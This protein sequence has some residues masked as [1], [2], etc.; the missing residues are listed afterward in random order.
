M[1]RIFYFLIFSG[2]FLVI[3]SVLLKTWL[4]KPLPVLATVG[5]FELTD[6]QSQKFSEKNL[7]NKVW[8]VD[9]IFTRC[10]GPCP[11]MTQKMQT[12]HNQFL[13]NDGVQLVTVTVDPEY[14]TPEILKKYAQKYQ[15]TPQKWHFLTGEK[16]KIESLMFDGFKLGFADDIVFHSDRL[17]LVDR[18][19]KIRGYYSGSEKKDFKRLQ[20]DLKRLL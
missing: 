8:V 19:L 9:F 13:K 16:K 12:L 6:S 3:F 11:L 20:N 14:D 10:Q 2:V 7:Q 17:I 4:Q 5:A 15:A 1:K 18:D